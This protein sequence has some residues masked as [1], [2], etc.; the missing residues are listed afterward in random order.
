MGVLRCWDGR[1]LRVGGYND[2]VGYGSYIIWARRLDRYQAF[3]FGYMSWKRGI[4]IKLLPHLPNGLVCHYSSRSRNFTATS[5][6]ATLLLSLSF[7][8]LHTFCVR[9]IRFA[10]PF[11]PKVPLS[12]RVQKAPSPTE[13]PPKLFSTI[14]LR[15]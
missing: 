2:L 3:G 5:S 11:T 13:S 15:C 9:G 4:E 12:L 7:S 6:P 10:I 14:R 8:K 1:W